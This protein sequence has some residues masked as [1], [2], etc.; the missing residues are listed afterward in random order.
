MR[1]DFVI[2]QYG[3]VIFDSVM[4]AMLIAAAPGVCTENLNPNVAMMKPT[5]DRYELMVP[6]RSTERKAGAS[7]S[8]DRCVLMLL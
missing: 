3:Q 8:S 6:A 7:L 1:S 5:K 4:V 2:P